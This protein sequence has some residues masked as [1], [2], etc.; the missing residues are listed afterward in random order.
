MTPILLVELS[1]I[2]DGSDIGDDLGH[3][4]FRDIDREGAIAMPAQ[5]SIA[6]CG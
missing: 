4:T 6:G 5:P 1:A 3:D 2:E